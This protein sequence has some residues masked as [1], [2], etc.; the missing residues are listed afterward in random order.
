MSS[1]KLEVL[2]SA[3][4]RDKRAHQG[5]SISP[6]SLQVI[7]PWTSKTPTASFPALL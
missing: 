2:P 1:L 6:F 5:V 4:R 7:W 3:S